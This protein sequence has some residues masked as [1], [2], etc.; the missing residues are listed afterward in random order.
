MQARRGGDANVAQRCPWPRSVPSIARE[1]PHRTP[2][3]RSKPG[4]LAP[5]VHRWQPPREGTGAWLKPL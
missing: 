2:A 1:G 3:R 4:D 5:G